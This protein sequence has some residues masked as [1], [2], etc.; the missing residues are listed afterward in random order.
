MGVGDA[1][2]LGASGAVG[3]G[4][5][6]ERVEIRSRR[7]VE[8][9]VERRGKRVWAVGKHRKVSMASESGEVCW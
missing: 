4:V 1:I 7:S 2:E 9:A 8:G 6:V 5:S 3:E